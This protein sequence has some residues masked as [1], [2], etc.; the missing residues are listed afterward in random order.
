[1][2]ADVEDTNVLKDVVVHVPGAVGIRQDD[3]GRRAK[4]PKLE[5]QVRVPAGVDDERLL[6][7][8]QAVQHHERRR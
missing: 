6:Q 4:S 2:A 7:P 5:G 8:A 3:R 1:M